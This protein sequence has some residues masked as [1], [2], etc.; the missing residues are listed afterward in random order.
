MDKVKLSRLRASA[1]RLIRARGLSAVRESEF[2][3]AL[4]CL[5][6]KG[7]ASGF[8]EALGVSPAYIS[9]LRHGRRGISDETL[10]RVLGL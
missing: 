3:E 8:A 5:L 2:K 4:Q 10:E 1:D 6:G 9:D 7:E